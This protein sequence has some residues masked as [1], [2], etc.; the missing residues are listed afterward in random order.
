MTGGG[1]GG[2]GG[3]ASFA[4][5]ANY[6]TIRVLGQGGAG[7]LAAS[8]GASWV[9]GRRLAA[10]APPSTAMATPAPAPVRTANDGR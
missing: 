4:D 9:R 3:N 7:M 6:G 10:A 2:S 5:L 1:A 8:I